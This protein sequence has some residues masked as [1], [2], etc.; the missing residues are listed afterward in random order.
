MLPFEVEMGVQRFEIDFRWFVENRFREF[1]HLDSLGL[2]LTAKRN[3]I[4]KVDA[5]GCLD[6]APKKTQTNRPDVE[7]AVRVGHGYGEILARTPVPSDLSRLELRLGH[8]EAGRCHA[9]L[10]T[11]TDGGRD[12]KA[13]PLES[14]SPARSRLPEPEN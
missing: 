11:Q 7:M 14:P 9:K 1:L 12:P 3:R 8:R 6:L 13:D 4:A 2:D 5:T 10:E